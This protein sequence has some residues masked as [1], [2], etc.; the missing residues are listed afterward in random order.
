MG[1]TVGHIDRRYR[2]TNE[3]GGLGLS[4]T[5]TGVSFAGVP[6]L[7]KVGAGFAPRPMTEIKSLVHAACGETMDAVALSRSLGLIA[8]ALNRGDLIYAMTAAVLTRLPEL[9]W[10][11]SVRLAKAEERFAK[12]DSDQAR[13][14]HGRWTT[15]NGGNRPASETSR[16]ERLQIVTPVSISTDN[17]PEV[18]EIEPVRELKSPLADLEEKY[19][20]LSPAQFA[21]QVI[22]FGLRLEQDGKNMSPEQREGALREYL[23]LQV[24][25]SSWLG[26]GTVEIN[27]HANLISAALNLY[28]GAVLGGVVT[29][30]GHYGDLPHSYMVAAA[31]APPAGDSSGVGGRRP[32]FEE[33]FAEEVAANTPPV[34][35]SLPEFVPRGKT[36]GALRTPT[37]DVTFTSGWD[38]PSSLMPS[39]SSGFD[40]VSKTH[41]EGHA[42]AYMRQCGLNEATLFINNPVV[43]SSCV[44]N[45]PKM[46]P[47]GATL[48][49][50]TG[51]GTSHSFTGK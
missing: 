29:V 26:D 1:A 14:W 48:Q 2:L 28:Q 38:G 25:L 32:A 43:C 19:D 35:P 39:G 41:V 23:F 34:A 12:Y 31:V 11:A 45:L 30:G 44:K 9:D 20:H 40:I 5:S 18:Q 3:P 8:H 47:S 36:T 42:A 33:D 13:D 4:C 17:L 51:D 37:E 16:T 27:A 10:E 46:L 22:R 7:C 6:L 24:R 21:D 50:F 49:I 15:G